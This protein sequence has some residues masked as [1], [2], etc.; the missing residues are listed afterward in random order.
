MPDTDQLE[1]SCIFST[2]EKAEFYS[3]DNPNY[4]A[5]TKI[6]WKNN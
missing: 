4:I 1:A 6:E 5:T 2:K 3:V